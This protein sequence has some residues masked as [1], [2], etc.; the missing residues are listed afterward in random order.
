MSYPI[1]CNSNRYYLEIYH[2][3]GTL[4]TLGLFTKMLKAG[5]TMN[6]TFIKKETESKQFCRKIDLNYTIKK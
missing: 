5:T 1:S 4:Y 6:A 3:L 2:M